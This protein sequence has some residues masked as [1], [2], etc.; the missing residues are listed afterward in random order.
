MKIILASASPRRKDLMDLAKFD[1]EIIPSNFDEKV[2]S[3]LNLEEQSKEIAYGKAKD[4]FDNTQGNRAIIG[5]DT[6]VIID[7]QQL[8]KPNSREEAIQMLTNLQGRSHTVYTSI[9]I[10]IEKNGELKEYKELSQ[11]R[12][13]IKK[14]TQKE[15]ENY[16]DSENPY[17]KAGG[18]AIQSSF[19]VFVDKIDGDFSTVIGLPI[20]RIYSILKENDILE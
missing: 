16:V 6:L 10:L 7:Q 15:I 14:M 4:I 19:V 12:I 3:K 1:Y 17:D 20:S 2:D 9:A 5:A 8:G 18:Y 13:W 11:T